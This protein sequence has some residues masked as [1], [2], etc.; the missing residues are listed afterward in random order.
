VLVATREIGPVEILV[1]D[2]FDF[3]S[4]FEFPPR[5]F[6]VRISRET[7][8]RATVDQSVLKGK[9]TLPVVLHADNDPAFSLPMSELV[10]GR[11]V[12]LHTHGLDRYRRTLAVIFVHGID[13][14]LEQVRSGMAWVYERYVSQAGA[15]IQASYRQAETE[16]WEQQRGLWSERDPYSAVGISAYCQASKLISLVTLLTSTRSADRVVILTFNQ[17]KNPFIKA[18]DLARY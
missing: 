7:P 1:K 17:R 4:T 3:L 16:A 8:K 11:E 9:N 15:N 2:L 14:N 5:H 18:A 12:E 10:F 6:N 13:A